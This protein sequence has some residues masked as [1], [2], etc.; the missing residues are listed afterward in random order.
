M[1]RKHGGGGAIILGVA[2]DG[3]VIGTA[4]DAEWLRHRIFELTDRALTVDVA[5]IE[6]QG[7]RLLILKTVE[8][9]EPVRFKGK[10]R[11]R[12]S[13]NCVEVDPSTWHSGRLHRLGWDW[14]A[15]PSGH[16]LDDVKPSALEVAK[17]YL[18]LAGDAAALRI[19]EAD[20]GEMLRRLHLLD[21]E[22]RLNNAGS[23][24]FV[25][26][27][28]EA[29]DYTRRS[30]PGGDSANRLRSRAPLLV[31]LREVE[32]AIAAANRQMHQ[33][34]FA[35]GQVHAVPPLA[36]REA[37]V[38]GVAHR[39][40][41]M[42]RPTVVHHIGDT[43]IVESPGGLVGTVTPENIITHPAQPRYQRLAQALADLKLAEGEGIG[44]DR[45]F[46]EMIRFG[47][48]PPV[49]EEVDGPY[50]RVSLVGGDP[51]PMFVE[52]LSKLQPRQSAEDLEIVLL[53][54][55]VVRVGWVDA[56]SAGPVLQRN[57]ALTQSAL[58]RLAST[59]VDDEDLA[60]EIAGVPE[61]A[62]VA[63]RLG[64]RSRE[65]L[66]D[67]LSYLKSTDGRKSVLNGWAERRGRVSSTEA[68]SILGVTVP[69]ALAVLNEMVSDGVLTQGRETKRGR[70]F[71][72]VPVT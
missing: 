41:D 48:E 37:I 42:R 52:L 54:H 26:T 30:V 8:A 5:E 49:I 32:K 16:T 45:M 71:F 66:K 6:F 36:V 10:I 62:P 29:L 18:H 23:L 3:T 33:G 19:A 27:P 35:R 34:A 13:K 38:N 15:Q 72:Y 65:I 63:Y 24:L 28:F 44:V 50:V 1:S 9:V 31:Q 4:L 39:S 2:D 57:E 64:K 68:A 46:Q 59:R 20:D 53:I 61:G 11:M 47:F 51:D 58:K 69:T 70:G 12:V 43:L 21:A 55:L 40:W 22:G 67:R 14:S 17:E 7:K 56:Q 25:G 60:M